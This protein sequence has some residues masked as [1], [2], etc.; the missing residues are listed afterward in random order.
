MLNGV[1]VPEG[2][3]LMHQIAFVV[4]VVCMLLWLVSVVAEGPPPVMRY[5]GVLPWLAVLCL[6]WITGHPS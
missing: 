1:Y 5:T 3:T 2:D 4:F 6:W